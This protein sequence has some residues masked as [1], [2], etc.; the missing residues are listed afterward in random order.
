MCLE[1]GCKR[2]SFLY[3][4]DLEKQF[5]ENLMKIGS[6]NKKVLCFKD[7]A[8]MKAAIYDKITLKSQ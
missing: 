4:K 8:V 6:W 3:F 5:A 7:H 2:E 1:I